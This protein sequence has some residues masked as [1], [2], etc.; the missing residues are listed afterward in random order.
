MNI[1]QLIKLLVFPL[2]LGLATPAQARIDD[3]ELVLIRTFIAQEQQGP[4]LYSGIMAQD[5]AVAGPAERDEEKFRRSRKMLQSEMQHWNSRIQ[6]ITSWPQDQAVRAIGDGFM[7]IVDLGY[8][9]S[10]YSSQTGSRAEAVRRLMSA[11]S[12]GITRFI[13]GMEAFE[14]RFYGNSGD[15]LKN[16]YASMKNIAIVYLKEVVRFID[17]RNNKALLDLYNEN[18]NAYLNRKDSRYAEQYL[19]AVNGLIDYERMTYINAADVSPRTVARE[20]A[21]Y[22]EKIETV[23]ELLER[24]VDEQLKRGN[25]DHARRLRTGFDALLDEFE[26]AKEGFRNKY[27]DA[28]RRAKL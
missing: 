22:S 10:H 21:S 20:I 17:S 7:E 24:Y 25:S 11:E 9:Y 19:N 23:K 13:E 26:K 12:E 15:G 8:F 27:P 3:A 18:R 5:Q 4:L 6:I 28:A 14:Q 16:A 1:K 2:L